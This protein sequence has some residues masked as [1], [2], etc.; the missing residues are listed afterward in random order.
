MPM[1][2]PIVTLRLHD[3]TV[4]TLRQFKP[5]RSSWDWF[6]VELLERQLD[7]EDLEYARKVL[8]DFRAGADGSVPLSGIR[9]RLLRPGRLK[10]D[11]A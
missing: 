4:R 9:N 8:R 6:L 5:A 7:W 11:A 3:S 10:R 1:P 2:D